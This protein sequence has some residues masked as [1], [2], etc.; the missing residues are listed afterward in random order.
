MFVAAL[1]GF[2]DFSERFQVHDIAINSTDSYSFQQLLKYSI[3]ECCHYSGYDIFATNVK[4]LQDVYKYFIRIVSKI[5]WKRTDY[6]L[7][8]KEILLTVL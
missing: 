5:R 4:H 7:D 6:G 8:P 1:L 2:I 3:L